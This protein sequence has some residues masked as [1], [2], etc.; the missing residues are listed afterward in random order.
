M[1]FI[2]ALEKLV[3][4]DLDFVSGLKK[5]TQ[6]KYFAQIDVLRHFFILIEAEFNKEKTQLY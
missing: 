3:H 2:Y 4:W 1:Y 5:K 6:T